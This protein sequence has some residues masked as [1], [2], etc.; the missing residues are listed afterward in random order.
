MDG[1]DRYRFGDKS[2]R[3]WVVQAFEK[4][5][6]GSLV[7]SVGI[8][9]QKKNIKISERRN[10][11]KQPDGSI[12]AENSQKFNGDTRSVDGAK[13]SLRARSLDISPVRSSAKVW[14]ATVTN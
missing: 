5:C 6:M 13:N 9:V 12:M 10:I 1:I 4:S 8:V 7:R 2:N 3:R 14:A 11:S